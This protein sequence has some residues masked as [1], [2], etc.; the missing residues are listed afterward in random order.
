MIYV[1]GGLVA[2]FL[3]L[4]IFAPAFRDYMRGMKT[5]LFAIAVAVLGVLEQSDIA[6][7]IP[8]EYRG[9][10]MIGIALAVAILRAVTRGP[11]KGVK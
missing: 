4:L 2:T 9:Y 1:V 8:E 5:M 3:A 11:V 7:M 6:P 10:W